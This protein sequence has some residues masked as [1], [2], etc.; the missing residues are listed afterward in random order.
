MGYTPHVLVIGGGVLGTGIAR[1]LVIRGLDVT[2]VERGALTAG[3]TGQSY[4]ILSSVAQFEPLGVDTKLVMR[5]RTTLQEIADH[6]I[7]NTGGL[8]VRHSDDSAEQF[9][10]LQSRLDAAEVEY[11][12]LDGEHA[13]DIEPALSS[14]VAEALRVPDVV[15][16]PLRLTV[17]NA[18][19]AHSYGARIRTHTEVTEIAVEDGTVGSVTV[20]H[21]PSPA[22]PRNRR[23]SDSGRQS[24]DSVRSDG[25]TP[26]RSSSGGPGR[27]SG[28]SNKSVPGAGK[29]QFRQ[30]E[31]PS[32]EEI[33]ADYII[34]ATGPWAREVAAL[35][36]F[37]VDVTLVAETVLT[38]YGNPLETVVRR[39]MPDK[40]HLTASTTAVSRGETVLLGSTRREISTPEEASAF[41]DEVERIRNV[42][43]PL[44]PAVE[45]T[46][47]LRADCG[48]RS[49]P[50][51]ETEDGCLL[52]DHGE[53]DA[54]WGMTTV[55][56][57][58]LTT[59]RHVAERV[60]DDVCAKF[61]IRRECQTDE[62]PTHDSEVPHQD[63]D[64]QSQSGDEYPVVCECQSVSRGAVRGALADEPSTDADLDE[65]RIRTSA[66]MGHCQGGRCA[67]RLAAELYPD[68]DAATTND[69]LDAFVEGR[70]EGQRPA[71]GGEHLRQAMQTYVV[72]AVTMNRT[73]P[74]VSLVPSKTDEVREAVDDEER[75]TSK[76]TVGLAGF[77]DGQQQ[78]GR[79]SPP[80][81]ERP[82]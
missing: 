65:V 38:A 52:V 12:H 40:E 73:T 70:W 16:D 47:I 56:G 75:T 20:E 58:S 80:W 78:R 33:D 48:V 18:R 76:N 26:G 60:A 41:P 3:T 19:S 7:E 72:S 44:V 6:C 1:D 13:Q 31:Q 30:P 81:G 42:V 71:L 45:E 54:C 21:D 46:R 22:G 57:G 2:L 51:V 37:E 66:G 8:L 34:N 15:V 4:G 24:S 59:H 9:E 11:E 53:V 43:T 23:H 14:S 39:W 29:P 10:Q 25:G 77:D 69:A 50:D 5:E 74:D 79:D 49:Y 67:H 27:G 63:S 68:Y 61:G 17:A 82:I 64:R 62:I 32:V 36:G 28:Q 55:I 35:A